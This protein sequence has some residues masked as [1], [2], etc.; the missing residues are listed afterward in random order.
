MSITHATRSQLKWVRDLHH[1][2]QRHE[3]QLFLAEGLK[4]VEELLASGLKIEAVFGTD[5]LPEFITKGVSEESCYH[6]SEMELEKISTLKTP[7]RVLAV[8]SVPTSINPIAENAAEPVLALDGISDPGNLGTI[9]RTAAWFGVRNIIC[10]TGSVDCWSPKVVQSAMGALFKMNI[11]Y[12]ELSD[13]V[14]QAIQSSQ[15]QVMAATLEGAELIDGPGKKPFF[16]IIGSE[17]H[18][19]SAEIMSLVKHKVKIHGHPSQI[20]SLNAAVAAGILLYK[21]SLR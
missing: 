13:L 9:I 8:A 12:G 15:Y 16:L 5:P 18:G 19:I 1:S 11:H 3:E 10:S 20:E 14:E 7:N 6:V 17:S 4:V 2:R 21:L